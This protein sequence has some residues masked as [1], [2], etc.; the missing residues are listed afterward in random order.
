MC[1]GGNIQGVFFICSQVPLF[2]LQ[3]AIALGNFQGTQNMDA[4][5][6]CKKSV[7]KGMNVNQKEC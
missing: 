6:L 7:Q 2:R 1:G 5:F 3:V 4:N